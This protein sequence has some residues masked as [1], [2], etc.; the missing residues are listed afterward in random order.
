MTIA[1]LEHFRNLLFE[2]EKNL[3]DLLSSDALDDADNVNKVRS[4]LAQIKDA[5]HR[6]ENNSYGE[7]KVC[8]GTVEKHRLEIQPESEICLDCI[9]EEEKSVLEEELFVA[10]RIYHALLPQ[11]IAAINGFDLAVKFISAGGVGGDY[12]D[13]L[14]SGKNGESRIIIADTVGKGLPAGLLISNLQGALRIFSEEIESPALLLTRLNQWFCRN[15]PMTKFVSLVC[16]NIRPQA[17]GSSMLTYTNAGHWPPVLVRHSGEVERLDPT[18]GL[19]GV[20]KDFLYQEKSLVMDAGDLLVLFTDGVTEAQNVEGIMYE[21]T[22]LIKF[23]QCN[24]FESC[25]ALLNNLVSHIMDFSGKPK[26]SDDLTLIALHKK[27]H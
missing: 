24:Q 25:E 18:G 2:R 7:C 17:D 11:K 26:F 14:P 22:G 15:L 3:N 9:S 10:S 19:L 5:F 12:Y 20:H 8:H 21:E 23:L 4:L 13:F 16:L 6:I 1:D 27:H